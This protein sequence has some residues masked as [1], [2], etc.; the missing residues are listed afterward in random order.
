[1]TGNTGKSPTCWGTLRTCRRSSQ[2][3][4][5]LVFCSLRLGSFSCIFPKL[6][7]YGHQRNPAK[8]LVAARRTNDMTYLYNR[9]TRRTP[10]TRYTAWTYLTHAKSTLRFR[11]REISEPANITTE[12]ALEKSEHTEGTLGAS[13]LKYV[14]PLCASLSLVSL[15]W[16]ISS[17]FTDLRTFLYIIYTPVK[18]L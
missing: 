2:A 13:V 16:A 5:K 9:I 11:L 12:M 18:S 6:D 10:V 8:P 14:V 1:M 15:V 4:P 7:A 3:L 17:D